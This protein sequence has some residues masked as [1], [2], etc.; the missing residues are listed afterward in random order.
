MPDPSVATAAF[1]WVAQGSRVTLRAGG[2][3]IAAAE[4]ERLGARRVLL[5]GGG[6]SSAPAVERLRTALGSRLAAVVEGATQ[7]VPDALA[8]AAV[9]RAA[10]VSADAVVT[11]GGGSVTGLG[12]AVAMAAS[13][14][15]VAVPTTYAGSE[16]TSVW[17]RTTAGRKVTGRDPR[18]LPV[19]VVYDPELC[20][21]MPAR[22]AAASGMN[23]LAHCV[24]AL[25]AAGRNPIT[26]VLAVE[27]ARRLVAG[28]P[29]IAAGG[30][31]TDTH[32][33]NLVGA[34]LAGLAF[35]QAGGGIH[36]RT[37]HVLGGGWGLPH[38]ET[39]A[40]VLPYAT[41]LV[42]WR[43]PAPVGRVAG[44]LGAGDA[45]VGL[46]ALRVALGLPESLAE[47]GMP[48]IGL[49]EAA[50]RI[51]AAAPDDPLVAGEQAVRAMLE[52]AYAGARPEPEGQPR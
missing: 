4:V 37:C 38:A 14:P 41:A 7:H 30:G 33:G 9:A 43:A 47:L 22:L 1:T 21:G 11:V 12:K 19:A 8:D 31:D 48:E 18:A 10:G 27:G 6:R 32:A 42:A 36:H 17:G 49:D 20:A 45:P 28:L 23:A 46:W 3:E 16:M 26:D 13:I 39:H 34:C 50:S 2:L 5:I 40:V 44:L 35:A 51:V 15:L 24:E 25:W 52:A 29:R